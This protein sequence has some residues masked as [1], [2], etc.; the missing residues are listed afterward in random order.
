MTSRK[1]RPARRRWIRP[2][3]AISTL[4]LAAV[5]VMAL[6]GPRAHGETIVVYKSPTC[7]CCGEWVKHLESHGFKV[8]VRQVADP[9]AAMRE[10]G[11]PQD[12]ASCHTALVKDYVI[13]GHVPAGD[14][15]RLLREHPALAGL[16][17]PGM[18]TGSPGMDG[19]RVPYN[20]IAFTANGTF[21]LYQEH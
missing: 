1:S 20:V 16:A 15:I 2:L 19:A 12:L 5:L 17:A 4:V 7:G 14:I 13:E 8:E 21:S 9:A 6:R 3:L 18:P 10:H 11:V